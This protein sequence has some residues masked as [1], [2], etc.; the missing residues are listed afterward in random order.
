LD[1]VTAASPP[2]ALRLVLRDTVDT[3]RAQVRDAF[4]R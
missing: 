3:A 1:V 2:G 4:L